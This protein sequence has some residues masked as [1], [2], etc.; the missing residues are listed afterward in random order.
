MKEFWRLVSLMVS[1]AGFLIVAG[2]LLLQGESLLSV[3]VKAV[4]AFAVLW[5]AQALLRALLGLTAS[6]DVRPR[7]EKSGE[8]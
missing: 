3:V 4:A 5:V 6:T 2:V 8:Q 1:L 7:S